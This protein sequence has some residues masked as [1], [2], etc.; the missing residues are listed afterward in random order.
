MRSCAPDTSCIFNQ[1]ISF[2]FY[3][4]L[5]FCINSSFSA[6]LWSLL[7][8][9]SAVIFYAVYCIFFFLYMSVTFFFILELLQSVLVCLVSLISPGL[10]SQS[11]SS[12]YLSHLSLL[13]FLCSFSLF[14]F[15]CLCSSHCLHTPSLISF[16]RSLTSRIGNALPHLTY[17]GNDVSRFTLC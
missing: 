9:L 10:F 4:S 8:F 6:S 3:I 11:I 7:C 13:S 14:P 5:S 15:V 16:I 17:F 1:S 2:F 12:R